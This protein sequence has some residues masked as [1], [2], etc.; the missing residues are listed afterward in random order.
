MALTKDDKI[1][2]SELV[3]QY[4]M[5]GYSKEF[6]IRDIIRQHHF[7]QA[8]VAKYWKAIVGRDF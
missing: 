3:K 2:L 1:Q 5:K 4:G 7:K 8:T 6:A